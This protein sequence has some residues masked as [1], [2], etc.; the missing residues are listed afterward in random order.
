MLKINSIIICI[1]IIVKITNSQI[2]P[3]PSGVP[4]SWNQEKQ[5]IWQCESY[6]YAGILDY[7]FNTESRRYTYDLAFWN[8]W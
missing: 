8:E 6:A 3:S 4:G 2:F 5:N 1:L 7:K